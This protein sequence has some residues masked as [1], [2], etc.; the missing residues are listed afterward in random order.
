MQRHS[1]PT[2]RVDNYA[3]R[4]ELHFG[5]DDQ[6]RTPVINPKCR[7]RD[8]TRDVPRGGSFLTALVGPV[9][10]PD[11]RA[12]W[13][14]RTGPMLTEFLSVEIQASGQP[15]AESREMR[16]SGMSHS[17]VG[18]RHRATQGMQPPGLHV[19]AAPRQGGGVVVRG[20]ATIEKSQGAL[21][22]GCRHS[23]SLPQ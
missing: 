18:T 9:V 10:A 6:L 2:M 4:P 16:A 20:T 15:A 8:T 17:C 22:E 12:G 14:R 23:P 19:L 7:G 13:A 3:R 21:F 11:D 1:H 5:G